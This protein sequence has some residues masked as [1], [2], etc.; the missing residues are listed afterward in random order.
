MRFRWHFIWGMTMN[1]FSGTFSLLISFAL[2]TACA[3]NPRVQSHYDASADFSEYH[4]YNFSEQA[5]QGFPG[6][7]ESQFSEAAER[8]MLL[9]GY[10]KADNPDV[11]IHVTIDVQN[12]SMAPKVRTCPRYGDYLST[13][14][15]QR[16]YKG[17][18]RHG[19]ADSSR[20]ICKYTEG[21]I[22]VDMIDVDLARVI[23]TGVSL[24]RIDETERNLI[25]ARY[26]IY[27]ARIMFENYPVRVQQQIAGK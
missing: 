20:T 8:Q 26:I 12:K 1:K 5:Y 9:R 3:S 24:V 15:V 13:G 17:Y 11:L 16:S 19:P 7:L 10:T 18:S 27:D 22:T 25:L 6:V 2:L 21:Q 4:T 14:Y 23:W